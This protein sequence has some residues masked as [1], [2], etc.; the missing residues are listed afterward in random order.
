MVSQTVLALANAVGE[1]HL[2]INA[3]GSLSTNDQNTFIDRLQRLI[4]SLAIQKFGIFSERIDSLTLTA[5]QQSYTIGIDPTSTNTANFAVPRPTK[6]N[7]CRL[8]LD[9]SIER[10]VDVVDYDTWASIRYKSASGPPKLVYYDNGYANAAATGT[11][12]TGF[13]TL[14]FYFVPDQNYAFQ[15]YTWQKLQQIT[16]INDLINYPE[17]YAEYLLRAMV[18]RT[19]NLFAKQ[20]TDLQAELYKEAREALT[21]A[22]SPSP[23]LLG[24]DGAALNDTHQMYYNWRDGGTEDW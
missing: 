11:S 6:V 1:E 14:N 12:M 19:A 24:G 23:M 3:G 10:Q 7:R 16:G 22:N 18:L 13:G 9:S 8:Y 4:D 15:L 21:A 20:P 2:V 17:G 5:T